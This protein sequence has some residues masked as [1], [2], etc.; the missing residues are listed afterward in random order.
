[1]AVVRFDTPF[2]PVPFGKVVFDDLM[3]LPGTVVLHC[4]GHE[5]QMLPRALFLNRRERAW[6]ATNQWDVQ[7]SEKLPPEELNSPATRGTAGTLLRQ[8]PAEGR[9]P[10]RAPGSAGRPDAAPR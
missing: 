10:S 6:N 5:V 9:S 3:Y 4:F 2:K 1:P 7:P 8:A